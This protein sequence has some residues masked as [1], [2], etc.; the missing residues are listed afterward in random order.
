MKLAENR[1]ERS[2]AHGRRHTRCGSSTVP[3]GHLAMIVRTV[4]LTRA[5][6]H[7]DDPL[8]R[9]RRCADRLADSL[10]MLREHKSGSVLA[11]RQ[12]R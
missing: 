4:P 5:G 3:V 9:C 11:T 1:S 8:P 2:H 7:G 6:V 12:G 10:P